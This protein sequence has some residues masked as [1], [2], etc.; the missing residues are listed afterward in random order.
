MTSAAKKILGD[1]LALPQ[2]EREELLGALTESLEPVRVTV[3]WE[4][5]LARRMASVEC[6]EATLLDAAIHASELRSKYG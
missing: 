5:E 3:E 1:A 4:A 6:G 2:A